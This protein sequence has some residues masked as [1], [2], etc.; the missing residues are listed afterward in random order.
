MT[1]GPCKDIEK[2]MRHRKERHVKME[3]ETGMM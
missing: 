2:E 3:A 1:D